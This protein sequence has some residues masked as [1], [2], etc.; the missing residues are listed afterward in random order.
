[1]TTNDFKL[2]LATQVIQKWD[3]K[4]EDD[5][6]SIANA[7]REDRCIFQMQGGELKFFL[8]FEIDNIEGKNHVFFQNLWVS[9]ELRLTKVLVC[10]KPTLRKLFPTAHKFYWFNRKKQKMIE[11]A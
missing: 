6:R 2:H 8:S 11:R 9:P 7:I 3:A 4:E 10:L 1:M 5:V